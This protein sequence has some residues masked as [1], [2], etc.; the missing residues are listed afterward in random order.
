MNFQKLKYAVVVADSGS[1][2]EAARRLFMAQSSLS[3]AIRELEEEYDIQIF[4][5]T[6]RGIFI[7]EEG[8]EFLSYARDVLSQVSVMENRYLDANQKK[9][10]SISSQHYDFVSE[11]FAILLATDEEHTHHYRLLE[12]ST[13][14]VMENVKNA[15]SE[16]GILY[17]NAYNQKVIKQYLNHNELQYTEMGTFQPHVFVGINHPLADRETVTQA[18]LLAYPSVT[19]EQAQGSSAQLTE[20]A[21]DLAEESTQATVYVSD[22]ATS[23]NV[24]V[25]TEAILVG[26]GILTSPFRDM[27]RTIPIVDAEANHMIYIQNKYRKLSA[28]AEHFIEILADQLT[29]VIGVAGDEPA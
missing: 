9:L 21:L 5:R 4:E 17:M 15:Y 11:A 6:K 22:R 23:I 16:I 28:E 3:T 20:E 7:T 12:T 14:H 24:L 2:R 25:K 29:D 18:D 1:F 13:T 8:S 19:F 10:F 27:M 26:T